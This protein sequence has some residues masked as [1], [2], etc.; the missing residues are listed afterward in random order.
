MTQNPS[1]NSQSNEIPSYEESDHV[2]NS[3]RAMRLAFTLNN[4]SEAEM[5]VI[6]RQVQELGME[7]LKGGVISKEHWKDCG[8]TPHLQGFLRFSKEIQINAEWRVRNGLHRA[9]IFRAKKSSEVNWNYVKKSGA[10]HTPH[11]PEWG[12]EVWI[13]VGDAGNQGDR[14]DIHAVND[15]IQNGMPLN[16]IA[17]T[18]PNVFVKYHGGVTDLYHRSQKRRRLSTFPRILV[19]YGATKTGKSH[20]AHHLCDQTDEEYFVK[21]PNTTKWWNGYDGQNVIILE[22]YRGSIPFSSLLMLLDRY[23]M[24][25]EYKGGIT[26][27][28]ASTFVI[29]SPVH[30]KLW[31]QNLG[32]EEGSLD[33]L[34]RRLFENPESRMINTT[35]KKQ[36]NWEEVPLPYQVLP[37]WLSASATETLSW[38]TYNLPVQPIDTL[39]EAS[40]VIDLTQE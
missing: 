14:S 27:I 38:P 39:I 25:V 9:A 7:H 24:Q 33:Q 20:M 4:P 28:Q 6:S 31:Y 32:A 1:Q 30:P 19:L 10:H 29:C 36:V 5:D 12:E 16:V 2:H 23:G 40:E 22:E 34:K 37:D 26:H 18:H 35:I 3:F 13:E 8:M 11:K 15:D 17:R 21:I